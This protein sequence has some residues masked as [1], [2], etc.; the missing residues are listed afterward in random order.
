VLQNPYGQ[1]EGKER[2]MQAP[3]PEEVVEYTFCGT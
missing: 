2:Y 3:Q 1:Q